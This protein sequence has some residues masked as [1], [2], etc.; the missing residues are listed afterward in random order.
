MP[1]FKE[2]FQTTIVTTS[3]ESGQ[4]KGQ[5]QGAHPDEARAKSYVLR[6]IMRKTYFHISSLASRVF[7][8]EAVEVDGLMHG[9]QR[10]STNGEHQIF[11][12]SDECQAMTENESEQLAPQRVEAKVSMTAPSVLLQQD[13]KVVTGKLHPLA[14]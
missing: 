7:K 11:S 10:A 8:W 13:S 9:K 4:S 12:Q 3:N 14:R 6:D 1:A 5:Q 2:T